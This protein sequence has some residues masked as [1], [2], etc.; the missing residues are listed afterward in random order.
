MPEAKDFLPL[1]A[2]V[3]ALYAATE[4]FDARVAA[5]LEV[6]RTALRAINAMEAGPVTPSDLARDLSLT[7][8][9]VTALIDRLDRAGHL[10]RVADGGDRRRRAV[11]LAPAARAV[12]HAEYEA[13]GRSIAEAFARHSPAERAAAEAALQ[14]LVRAFDAAGVRPA[15]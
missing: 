8:G 6:D 15:P 12:A 5:R 10:L 13:L 7:S 9:S 14:A 4:R 2:A 3:R 1:M 11:A